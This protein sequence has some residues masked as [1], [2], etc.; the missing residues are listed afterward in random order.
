[1]GSLVSSFA[2]LTGSSVSFMKFTI[3]LIVPFLLVY[4]NL[5]ID[6]FF[7]FSLVLAEK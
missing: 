4:Y 1:M 7:I 3:F 6:I 5:C 2:I